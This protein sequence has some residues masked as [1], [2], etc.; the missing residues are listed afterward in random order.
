MAKDQIVRDRDMGDKA[1]SEVQDGLRPAKMRDR[2]KLLLSCFHLCIFASE[3]LYAAGGV[4]KLLLACKERMA[5]RA[6][7]Y[8]DIALVG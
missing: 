1:G 3:T 5:V 2:K 7:F 6:D 8:V 4:H